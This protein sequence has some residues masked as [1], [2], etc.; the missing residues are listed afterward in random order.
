MGAPVNLA[1]RLMGSKENNGILVDEAVGKQAGNRF[2]FK[3]L[4]PVSAKG[5]DKPV[6][7]LEPLAATT[8]TR[9]KKQA[10][11]FSGRTDE[12]GQ[13]VNAAN[14]IL[15]HAPDS[16]SAMVFVSGESGVGKSALASSA[17]DEI[18][19]RGQADGNHTV[20]SA[21][22]SSNETAQRIPLSSFRQMFLSFIRD[23][24]VFDGTVVKD[25]ST[26][27]SSESIASSHGTARPKLVMRTKNRKLYESVR[28]LSS[29]NGRHLLTLPSATES[30]TR[31][32]SQGRG[33]S[34]LQPSRRLSLMR[35]RGLRGGQDFSDS[36]S[37]Q[38]TSVQSHSSEYSTSQSF[39]CLVPPR[40]PTESGKKYRPGERLALDRAS[41]HG[42]LSASMHG[43]KATLD[44]L[45]QFLHRAPLTDLGSSVHKRRQRNQSTRFLLQPNDPSLGGYLNNKEDDSSAASVDVSVQKHT[46]SVP[47]FEKLC[48]ICEQLEYPFEYADIV[49]SQFLGLESANPLTHIDGHVPTMEELVE[50]LALA[51]VRITEFADL[52]VVVLDDFQWVD[53]FSWKIFRVLCKRGKNM[54]LVCLS[55]SHDQQA[56]RRLRAALNSEN[57][58]QSQMTEIQLRPLSLPDFRALIA[59]VLEVD[60]PSIPDSICGDLYQR[61]AGLPV[62]VIQVLENI[63][64]KGTLEMV[65]SVL[66]WTPEGLKEN[67]SGCCFIMK[68]C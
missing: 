57:E 46:A 62:F 36:S 53:A 3:S 59:A 65:D 9:K 61:T 44:P 37:F 30:S 15:D 29:N 47:Y 24:C 33:M 1:A 14:V 16:Q 27:K 13:I 41:H 20:I 68:L 17:V 35:S 25:D 4:P 52:N 38:T 67:V 34:S 2:S 45:S 22:S 60:L 10:Y 21:R 56:L 31:Q 8:A 11:K 28:R 18:V 40:N 43:G 39:R 55:R 6:P 58:L 19:R 32:A 26:L 51:F 63:K 5:Y 50:F 12:K 23:H 54:L 64:R 66:K 48:W 7:I 49:G 42:G